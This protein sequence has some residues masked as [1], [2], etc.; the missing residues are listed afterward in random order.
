MLSK[1]TPEI[2]AAIDAHLQHYIDV[3]LTTPPCQQYLD[4]LAAL[5]L[6]V[7]HL[8]DQGIFLEKTNVDGENIPVKA[9]GTGFTGAE[10]V[11]RA[12]GGLESFNMRFRAE[13]LGCTLYIVLGN[14]VAELIC[15]DT[16]GHIADIASEFLA[17]LDS[18]EEVILTPTGV[19]DRW[20]NLGRLSDSADFSCS[21]WGC[22]VPGLFILEDDD[23]AGFSVVYRMVDE[24]G[25]TIHATYATGFPAACA[26]KLAGDLAC[27]LPLQVHTSYNSAAHFKGG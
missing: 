22:G 6:L 27:R 10:F 5:G 19:D 1:S 9:A 12:A 23:N 26:V 17:D 15:D 3:G 2:K 7:D 14:S 8:R 20:V 13:V 24:E 16:G 21:V 25:N 18:E 11:A 4:E